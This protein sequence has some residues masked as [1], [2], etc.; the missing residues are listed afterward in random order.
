MKTGDSA[1]MRSSKNYQ[2]NWC[3]PWVLNL[4]CTLMWA[5]QP[6]ITMKNFMQEQQKLR[7]DLWEMKTLKKQK[8]EWVRKILVIT[9]KKYPV[10]FS[11]WE[12]AT[13]QKVLPQ[14]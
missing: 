13:N 8:S 14:V 6:Y 4:T 1:H 12:Q 9:R 11:G 5:I 3:I 2:Q 7:G 10:V